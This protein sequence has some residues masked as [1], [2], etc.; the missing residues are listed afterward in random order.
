M[1][2]PFS[3]DTLYAR[4]AKWRI[5]HGKSQKCL[6]KPPTIITGFRNLFSIMKFLSIQAAAENIRLT[7]FRGFGTWNMNFSISMTCLL[8]HYFKYLL[9]LQQH[10]IKTK[11]Q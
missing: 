9:R 11:V 5:M 8:I 10:Q 2:K 6:E 4:E 3:T 7:Q 1:H